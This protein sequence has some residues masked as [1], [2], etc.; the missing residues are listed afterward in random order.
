MGDEKK[1]P[2]WKQWHF[3]VRNMGD[4][5]LVARD[6]R[7]FNGSPNLKN[8]QQLE[9]AGPRMAQLPPPSSAGPA[10]GE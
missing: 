10:K 8:M 1:R 3:R 7:T 4:D 6:S 9:A 2:L 5:K